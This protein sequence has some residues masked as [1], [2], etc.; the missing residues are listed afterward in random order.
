MG[1][2][3]PKS[4]VDYDWMVYRHLPSPDFHRLDWQP[5]GLRAETSGVEACSPSLAKWRSGI[6][7]WIRIANAS[8]VARPFPRRRTRWIGE[9]DKRHFFGGFY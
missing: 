8:A 3:T 7:N 5:Y 2:V 4:H 9:E 1:R 6:V